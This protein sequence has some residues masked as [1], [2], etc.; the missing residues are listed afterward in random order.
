MA[1]TKPLL[2]D[3][4]QFPSAEVLRGVLRESFPA[5]ETL[6]AAFTDAGLAM[7]WRFYN[8]G[9]AWL[10]RVCRG[11]KTVTWLSAW[12]GWFQTGFFFTEKHVA[13][14]LALDISEAVK[15]EFCR[16]EP[17]WKLL[18]LLI[19]VHGAEQ[20]PDVLAVAAFKKTLK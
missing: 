14:V 3:P 20:L 2:N 10:C 15:E 1:Q 9:K 12:D 18:P 16:V 8:D 11:K 13:Q 17:V 19:K 5:F 4:A 6:S 7:E